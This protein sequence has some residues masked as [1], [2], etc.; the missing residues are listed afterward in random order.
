[1]RHAVPKFVIRGCRISGE[2]VGR[3]PLMTDFFFIDTIA[4]IITESRHELLLPPGHPRR[5]LRQA[6]AEAEPDHLHPPAA[7]GAGERLRPDAL[8]GR[9]HQGG[10]GHEDQPHRGQGP[11]VVPKPEGQ[12]AQGRASEGGAAE[13]RRPG[14]GEARPGGDEGREG[15]GDELPGGGGPGRRAGP[16]V[17]QPEQR[18]RDPGAASGGDVPGPGLAAESGGLRLLGAAAAGAAALLAHVSLRRQHCRISSGPGRQLRHQEHAA[19]VLPAPPGLP[20]FAAA[21]PD[22]KRFP[23][24]LLLLPHQADGGPAAIWRRVADFA[25][26]R[27]PAF[28]QCSRTKE[29]SA[30]AFRRPPAESPARGQLPA[31]GWTRQRPQLSPAAAVDSAGA[32]QETRNAG[33]GH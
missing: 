23:R 13:A 31:G 7:G 4:P 24:P 17:L 33:N 5:H 6:E 32:Q 25:R 11:G 28:V 9:L 29:E 16:G 18:P 14:R 1:M 2:R 26:R 3:P 21:L 27:R 19:P 30:G 8:P 12:M 15:R 20:I 22:T 10:P